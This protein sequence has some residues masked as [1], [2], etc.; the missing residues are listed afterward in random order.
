LKQTKANN[1]FSPVSLSQIYKLGNDQLKIGRNIEFGLWT[2]RFLCK[3][4]F[5]GKK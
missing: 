5:E 1:A 4:V 2:R 3:R